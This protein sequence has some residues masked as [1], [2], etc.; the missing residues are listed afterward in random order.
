MGG[1]STRST[2]R[3]AYIMTSDIRSTCAKD[4]CISSIYTLGIWIRCVG[5]EDTCTKF[6]YTN[7]IFV[8]GIEPKVL[9][10]S[11]VTLASPGINDCCFLLFLRLIFALIKG[12][13]Y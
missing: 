12:V 6:I 13:S 4:T 8:G 11:R 5:I 2:D 1:K 10:G 7:S 9:A 3:S